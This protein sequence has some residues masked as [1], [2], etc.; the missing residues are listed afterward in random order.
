MLTDA[1]KT[2]GIA[3]KYAV[4]LVDPSA[5]PVEQRDD[6]EAGMH[7][8][9]GEKLAKIEEKAEGIRSNPQ[10]WIDRKYGDSAK[11]MVMKLQNKFRSS[12]SSRS[13]VFCSTMSSEDV[14]NNSSGNMGLKLPS[15]SLLNTL[16]GS[17]SGVPQVPITPV[18]PTTTS[19][20]SAPPAVPKQ[21]KRRGLG[22]FMEMDDAKM[23]QITPKL[24]LHASSTQALQQLLADEIALSF[25]STD[26][27]KS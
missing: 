15:D 12:R 7:R 5:V 11:K 19:T 8:L 26:V 14:N 25:S 3:D 16:V 6:I 1:F 21:Q 18:E 22:D 20:S 24:K 13:E 23:A 2:L 9:T 27:E 4:Y 17:P 10:K